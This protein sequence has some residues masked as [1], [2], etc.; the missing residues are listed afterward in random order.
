MGIQ[1]EIV[2]GGYVKNAHQYLSDV[3][4]LL[5]TSVSE[6]LGNTIQEAMKYQIPIVATNCEGTVDLVQHQSSA[7]L[8]DIGDFVGLAQMI[9]QLM[10][11]SDLADRLTKNAFN[12]IQQYDIR[13]TSQQVYDLYKEVLS[14]G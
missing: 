8:S 2:V 11:D 12:L 1:E 6:G 10:E 4:I 7:L 13:T 14:L 5:S 9:N 3:D